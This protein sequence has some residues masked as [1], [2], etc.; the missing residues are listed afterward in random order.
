MKDFRN[1]IA[2]YV[3]FVETSTRIIADTL[4]FL[5]FSILLFAISLKRH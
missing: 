2:A 3:M 1:S 5:S 4:I